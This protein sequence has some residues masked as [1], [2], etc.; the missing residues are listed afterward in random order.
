[1]MPMPSGRTPPRRSR[2]RPISATP[3]PMSAMRLRGKREN[4]VDRAEMMDPNSDYGAHWPERRNA[5]LDRGHAKDDRR[6]SRGD[7]VAL[8]EGGDEEESDRT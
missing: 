3:P 7:R 6:A 2:P 4:L 5:G 1:M 8:T